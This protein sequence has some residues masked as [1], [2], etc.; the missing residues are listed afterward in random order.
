MFDHGFALNSSLNMTPQ[1][2]SETAASSYSNSGLMYP[3]SASQGF[4]NKGDPQYASDGSWIPHRS[5]EVPRGFSVH[6]SDRESMSS[7]S[8]K[9]HVS[10]ASSSEVLPFTPEHTGAATAHIAT[11]L[12]K[13]PRLVLKPPSSIG[14]RPSTSPE[15]HRTAWASACLHRRLLE[16]AKASTGYL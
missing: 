4:V 16:A 13:R 1:I 3:G 2:T 7:H 14:S 8:P 10:E 11:Q 9:T 15:C 6:G 5:T 12:A